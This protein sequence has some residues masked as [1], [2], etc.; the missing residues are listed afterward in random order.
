MKNMLLITMAAVILMTGMDAFAERKSHWLMGLAIGGGIG[1]AVGIAGG[2][3]ASTLCEESKNK[4]YAF[5]PAA[6]AIGLGAI[7]AGLGA[8]IGA[9]IPIKDTKEAALS[10]SPQM[11][12][13]EG[14]TFGGL[15]V[16]GMF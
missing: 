16:Y 13:V 12:S 2:F 8:A 14:R 11:Y 6:G 1:A 7:G 3:G 15:G 4:C 10:I 5:M 9:A